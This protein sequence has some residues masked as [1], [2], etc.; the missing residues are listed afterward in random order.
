MSGISSKDGWYVLSM[1]SVLMDKHSTYGMEMT[2]QMD[3]M[4]SVEMVSWSSMV[5]GSLDKLSASPFFN[6]FPTV[7]F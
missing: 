2:L 4:E 3:L 6:P 7:L 1:E 5:P